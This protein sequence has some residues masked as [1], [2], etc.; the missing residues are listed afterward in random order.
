MDENNRKEKPRDNRMWSFLKN[1]A[2]FFLVLVLIIFGWLLFI[3]FVGEPPLDTSPVLIMVWASIIILI[4]AAYPKM[5]ER[6]RRIKVK[7]FELELKEDVKK[8]S[9]EVIFTEKEL[10]DSSISFEKGE[11]SGV[12][13]LL[14]IT[15]SSP[16]KSI[17]LTV[18]LNKRILIPV[19]FA[20]LVILEYVNKSVI[21]LFVTRKNNGIKTIGAISGKLIIQYFSNRFTEL[22]RLLGTIP[23]HDLKVRTIPP[24]NIDYIWSDAQLDELNSPRYRLRVND[25]VTMFGKSL[26]KIKVDINF[27]ESDIQGLR[28]AFERE[29]EFLLVYKDKK[30]FSVIPICN[31]AII[32]TNKVIQ[33]T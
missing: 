8:A 27:N 2:S 11:I 3:L 21:V 28:K 12:W 7:D 30:L 33:K 16:D 6:I 14:D 20:Y 26:N 24:H 32:I 22:N 13:D 17:L 4:I 23:F 31:I 15:E 25:V 29:D 18:D 10:K 9:A 19:L 5:L 1:K